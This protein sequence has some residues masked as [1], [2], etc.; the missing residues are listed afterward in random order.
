MGDDEDGPLSFLDR[1]LEEERHSNL[2]F[3]DVRFWKHLEHIDSS[4]IYRTT[5]LE[6]RTLKMMFCE[7]CFFFIFLIILTAYLVA[8]KAGDLYSSRQQQL[9]YWGGCTMQ[10]TTRHCKVEDVYDI[11]SLMTW[12]TDD[13]APL[14]F[15]DREEYP[16]VVMSPSVFRLQEGTMHWTPRYVGDTKTSILVGTIRMRQVRVQY[17]KDCSILPTFQDIVSDCFAD[18]NEGIQ[19]RLSW[20]PAWTPPHLKEHYEWRSRN[21]TEQRPFVG[22][23]ATYPGDGF[24]LDLALN[25]TGAVTR[26]KELEYWKWI[27]IRT[28]A[29]M[30]ELTTFNP[31]VNS[32][33]HS[34][35]LFEF[36]AAGGVHV[37]Q[38]AFPFRAIQLSLS[39]MAADDL[40]GSFVYFVLSNGFTLLFAIYNGFLLYKNGLRFFSYFW[41]NVDVASLLVQFILVILKI[42]IFVMAD[43]MPNLGPDVVGDPEMFYN[44]GGLV[45]V[46]ESVVGFQ[47]LLGLITW[48]RVLKYLTLSR[49][50]LPFVRV[51][52]K[53]FVQLLM[54]F[55]LLGVVLLGFAIAIYLSY[56]T[57]TGI[58][59]SIWSTFIA[60]AVAPVGGVSFSPIL[61]D[62]GDVIAPI[63]LFMYIFLVIL[64]VLT[65][66]NAIQVDSYTVVTY[67]VDDVKRHKPVLSS[68]NPTIIFLW[69]YLNALKGVKLVGKETHEDIGDPED[70]LIAL[71]SLPEAV[72]VK[73]IKTKR[74]MEKMRDNALATV[75]EAKAQKRRE[76][77]LAMAVQQ[78]LAGK[79]AKSG[80]SGSKD[81]QDVLAALE[82][83]DNAGEQGEDDGAFEE[84]DHMP[85][86]DE[87]SHIHVNRVQLQRM[88]EEDE[89]LVEI[90]STRKAVE[91]VRR[92][93][94]DQ[95]GEDPYEVVARLQATVT[96]K[97]DELEKMGSNLTF[98]EME[99]LRV[100]SQELH[101]CL[102]ES[103]K[104]WRAELLTVL[105]M[106]SLLS[107]AL[108]EMTKK[109]EQVQIN[110]TELAIR[111]APLT[112]GKK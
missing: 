102:T 25:L 111:A 31:N 67:Q 86:S 3:G 50:F 82:D 108:I 24:V 92:F 16:S 28:R 1:L 78:E 40:W 97:L 45:P 41:S 79:T 57:E 110:H 55:N 88:L 21:I 94:V 56:G 100:M 32:F 51:F 71:S 106:A 52:E 75:E 11:P 68:G 107:T 30:I 44:I 77:G 46:M 104:E 91:V 6:Y 38:E 18:F 89:D 13:F 36:P 83:E 7:G 99:T 93:R 23:Y 49:T 48:L 42:Q 65:T 109:I 72:A 12:L 43:G 20:A 34:R 15:T 66:F 19:S 37:T 95:S 101:S 98:S 70:Q 47:A 105:Q 22:K 35:I 58:F 14:A 39:L 76:A 26:M 8:E 90:C 60:V 17:S 87:S 54:Y 81:V 85:T 2:Y 29:F 10:G 63:I 53:C 69:T 27:D 62:E 80:K 112:L 103:Q 9:D 59:S 64:L 96:Q 33:V 5:S 73:Y 74:H 84:E 4:H 61:S